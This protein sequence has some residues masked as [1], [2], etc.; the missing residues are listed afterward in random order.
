MPHET[1]L[2]WGS[3]PGAVGSTYYP[4]TTS[5]P[6]PPRYWTGTWPKHISA[7]TDSSGPPIT[8]APWLKAL[9]GGN[10]VGALATITNL[11]C[12]SIIIRSHT[13]EPVFIALGVTSIVLNVTI[14]VIRAIWVKAHPDEFSKCFGIDCSSPTEAQKGLFCCTTWNGFIA[15]LLGLG[16]CIAGFGI[17]FASK[18]NVAK[19]IGLCVG[20]L[21]AGL[22]AAI[23]LG[24]FV[25]AKTNEE[26]QPILNN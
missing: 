22:M 8:C 11:A 3:F 18:Y 25:C 23:P 14:L 16:I 20:G 13:S 12:M 24:K 4:V 7:M 17:G 26:A 19:V 10:G 6:D 21:S 1:R 5:T 9:C 15:S 2:V